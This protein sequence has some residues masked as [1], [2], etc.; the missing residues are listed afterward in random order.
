MH[1]FLPTPRQTNFLLLLGFVSIGV[2][3]YLRLQL[4][5]SEPLAAAC[6][7]G[8]AR[9]S[10]ELRRFI[11]ELYVLEVFGGIALIASAVH[12]V[13]P[14]VATFSVALCAAILGLFLHNVVPS[15]FAAAILVMS[16]A[17]PV[18]GGRP[19]RVRREAPRATP[20]AN[21]KVIH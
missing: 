2:G 6:F 11:L 4:V 16:F 8:L 9:A 1:P 21:S 17:R 13:R 7:A 20:P 14:D 5:G 12:F 18:R 3:L 10:C 19:R 15:A